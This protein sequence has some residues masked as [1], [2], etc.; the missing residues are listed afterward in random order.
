MP[1]KKKGP[2]TPPPRVVHP[3][4]AGIDVGSEAH[5]VAVGPERDPE[6]V[7]TFGVFTADLRTLTDWL[8]QCGV[9]TIVLESTG[10]YWMSLCDF[11]EAQGF[12]VL[13]V[14][15]RSLARNL[16]KKTDVCDAVWLQE[17]HAFG[18][19]KSCFRPDQEVRALRTLWRHR[20]HV[21]TQAPK[22]LQMIPSAP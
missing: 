8:R 15:P 2:D 12:E 7:R 20:D 4:A 22:L 14:D 21:I 16:K 11:L 1:V 6:P 3:N 17:L 13:V 5:V 18:M 19:L 9:T 10:V